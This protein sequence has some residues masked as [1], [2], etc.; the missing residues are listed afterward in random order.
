[1]SYNC[2]RVTQEEEEEEVQIQK[3]EEKYQNVQIEMM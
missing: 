2:Q 1:M 3:E